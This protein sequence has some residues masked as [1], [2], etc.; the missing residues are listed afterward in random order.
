MIPKLGNNMVFR[1]LLVGVIILLGFGL[2][3]PLSVKAKETRTITNSHIK[4]IPLFEQIFILGDNQDEV[5]YKSQFPETNQINEEMLFMWSPNEDV[6]FFWSLNSN[7]GGPDLSPYDLNLYY[8]EADQHFSLASDGYGALARFSTDGSTISFWYDNAP[9]IVNLKSDTI[10]ATGVQTEKIPIK[11]AFSSNND[12]LIYTTG[13]DEVYLRNLTTNIET[14]LG[15]VENISTLPYLFPEWSPNDQWV[16]FLTETKGFLIDPSGVNKTVILSNLSLPQS[17]FSSDLH[18]FI[19]SDGSGSLYDYN[20]N[21]IYSFTSEAEPAPILNQQNSSVDGNFEVKNLDGELYLYDLQSGTNNQL[22][23]NNNTIQ[24]IIDQMKPPQSDVTAQ[25]VA[26][27]F[28]YPVGKPNGVGYNPPGTPIAG[29]EWLQSTNGCGPLHPGVDFNGNASGDSDLG[30]P[31]YAVANGVVVYS[32]LYTLSSFGNIILIQHT[33][34]DGS[35]VWSQYAHLR[36]RLKNEGDVVNKGD[37]IGTIGKG[38]NNMYWAHL[39]FE[40]RIRWLE[41]YSWP[42]NWPVSTVTQYYINPVDYINNHR[43]IGGGTSCPTVSG[44][45]RLYDLTNCGGDS[46]TASHTGLLSVA[47]TFN[48]RAESIAIPSGW[49][50]RLYQNDNENINESACF[51]NTDTNLN[52]NTFANGGT[53]GGSTTYLRA[54]DQSNCPNP[55]IDGATFVS[56]SG[57]PTVSPGQSFQIYFQVRNTGTSI[58]QPGSYWLQNRESSLGANSQQPLGQSVSPNGTYTWTINL[59]APSSPGTY[60]SAWTVNH[61][62]TNFGPYMFIDVTVQSG[63]APSTPSNP[64]LNNATLS[65]T[66]N[67]S[68]TWITNGTSCTV[69]VWGGSI[70]INS[71]SGSCTNLALGEQRGGAYS[72]QVTASNS[73]GSSTGPVWHFNVKPYAPTGLN[74]SVISSSQINLSWT[75][76]SDDDGTNVDSYEIYKNSQLVGSVNKGVNTFQATGLVCNT[77]YSFYVVS[78]RQNV[79]SDGGGVVNATTSACGPA[80]PTLNSPANNSTLARTDNVVLSWNSASGATQY[81]VHFWGGPSIDSYTGWTSGTS[82][83]LGSQWGGVYQW[84]VEASNGSVSSFSE[85]RT[86]TIL[87]GSPSNLSATPISAAQVNLSWSASADA[88]GNIQGYR[89]YRNG[90]AIATVGS[91]TTSYNDTSLSCGTSYNFTVK[92]YK[93]SLESSASNTAS[94]S[95]TGCPPAMPSD[96][97]INGATQ[98]SLT[99]TWQDNSI[100]ES[101]FK[102]YRWGYDGTENTFLYLDTVGANITTFT[103]TGLDC[104]SDFNYY[105]VSAYNINGESSHAGWIQGTTSPCP[106]TELTI[107]DFYVSSPSYSNDD[108]HIYAEVSNETDLNASDFWIDFYIDDQP[109]GCSYWGQTWRRIYG[110]DPNSSDIW[111]VTLPAGTLSVGEHTIRAFVDSGCEV[112]ETN[113]DNNIAGPL[114]V[115]VSVPPVS[116]PGH[117]DFDS[118][119]LMSAFP[120]TDIVDVRGATRAAD[121]PAI[122]GCNLAPGTASVWY[123]YTP[124]VNKVMSLDTFGSDYD[125]YLAIWTG[126][127]GSLTAIACNDDYDNSGGNLQSSINVDL[128]GG[129]T[130]YIEIAQWSWGVSAASEITGVDVGERSL[131]DADVVS[132]DRSEKP[133]DDVN[134]QAGGTLNFHAS[135]IDIYRIYVPLII[136]P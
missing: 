82:T 17:E 92:A 52:D 113:E 128:I 21:L 136:R 10:S 121:D 53:V 70:D 123:K 69:H 93:D 54:F 116:A 99:L 61:S 62:G 91:S 85:T 7:I 22:T 34:P 68:L 41:A 132:G 74:T 127:R 46:I 115:T 124:L 117:D 9:F 63:T 80:S 102:I 49:S 87:Y 3:S 135:V 38:L 73:Y 4:K 111:S 81:R 60:R 25:A 15:F 122:T 84:S 33:L 30:D 97:I 57:Y 133:R 19:W 130:Y 12:F 90:S 18:Y 56:Q 39:H 114:T 119:R 104:G 101:G 36:D 100:N 23:T 109:G 103:Q 14:D 40:I 16:A 27:G 120:Y 95:T 35:Q 28:D 42:S 98:T 67:T 105:E 44:E 125:T 2:S 24:Q 65:R 126:T 47:T 26:T 8:P 64:N 20:R 66:N 129:T 1:I 88:P 6:L 134:M 131:T 77:N 37:L 48:D 31:V 86:L 110:L 50:V 32:R 55:V 118:A 11:G 78:K 59:T 79:L 71:P 83:S 112:D 107:T 5:S 76:S 106:L 43:Q 89:I 29:C 108:I 45:V 94:A 58:W 96:L 13:T 72:W 75:K 51:N